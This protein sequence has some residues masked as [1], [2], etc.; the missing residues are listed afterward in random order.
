MTH[1]LLSLHIFVLLRSS[2]FDKK[3]DSNALFDLRRPEIADAENA[4]F[5]FRGI[6]PH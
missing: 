5:G 1:L 4:A 2:A 6:F 3:V